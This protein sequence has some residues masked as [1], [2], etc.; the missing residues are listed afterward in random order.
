MKLLSSNLSV[1][2]FA[3]KK[4]LVSIVDSRYLSLSWIADANSEVLSKVTFDT[5]R[6]V[7]STYLR[8]PRQMKENAGIR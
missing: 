8:R 1:S 5:K 2:F 4:M 7:L 6:V 3:S